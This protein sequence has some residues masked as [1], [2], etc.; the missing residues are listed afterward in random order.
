MRII[1]RFVVFALCAAALVTVAEAG[2]GC[3]GDSQSPGSQWKRVTTA[4]VSGDKPVKLNLGTYRLGDRVRLAW[5][6]SGPEKPPVS[7]TLRITDMKTGRGYGYVVTPE[8]EGHAI[9]RRDDQAILLAMVPG[10]YRVYFG[11]RFPPA[12]G[13]GYDIALTVFTKTTTP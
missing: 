12:R 4:Q 1:A 10:Y 8:S 7:L 6:L 11:Q 9:L 13:P 2:G 5:V 3:G